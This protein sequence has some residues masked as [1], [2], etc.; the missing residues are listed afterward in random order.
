MRTDAKKR[1][2][3]AGWRVG[4]ATDF[5]AL[6][7]VEDAIVDMKIALAE[8]IRS[9][10]HEKGMTQAELARRIGS[11]QSRVAKI[12]AGDR[13]VSMD[14]LVRTLFAAGA[15]RDDVARALGERGR[16]FGSK[17]SRG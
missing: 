11:S 15:E 6:S 5:L 7:D 12:E 1:L 14:L 8:R 3:S 17:R 13:S 4:N 16:R 10:R 2:E 9:V